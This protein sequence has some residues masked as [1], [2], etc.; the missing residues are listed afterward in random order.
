VRPFTKPALSVE[1]QLDLLKQR[2]LLIANDERTI[3]FLEVVSLFRL[4]PYMRP[5]QENGDDHQFKEGSTLKAVVHIYRFDAELRHIVM[6]AIERVEVAIRAC[7]S[8]QMSPNHGAD[9]LTDPS[10]FNTQKFKHPEFLAEITRKIGKEKDKLT[11]EVGRI[12]LTSQSGEIKQ[13]RIDSRLRANYYRFYGAT[14]DHPAIPPSWAVLEEL[15]LGDISFLFGSLSRDADKKAIAARFNL[16]AHVLA[17]C[18]HTLTFIRNCCAH[19]SRL[20]NRELAVRPKLPNHWI[21][22]HVPHGRPRPPDR[23]YIVLTLLAYLTDT[24]SPD[25]N[26]KPRISNLLESYGFADSTVQHLM[27]FPDNWKAEPQWV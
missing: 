16:P 14:Y 15:S 23:L 27:G 5:F 3:R 26:W 17:S 18:L 25:S 6:A 1:Q 22:P 8:N 7:I 21:V 24:I 12:N 9:W 19:H 4:S 10:N 11:D 20:W 13:Q 2:G